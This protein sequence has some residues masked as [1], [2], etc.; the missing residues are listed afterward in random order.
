MLTQ[1]LTC[2]A[3]LAAA[4][5][6]ASP[7]SIQDPEPPSKKEVKEVVER[8]LELD[9]RSEAGWAERRELLAR[10]ELLPPLTEK[11]AASWRKD[12]AKRHGRGAE[13][14]SK[15]GRHWFF[16]DEERGKYI[17][18]GK[19]RRPKG[20]L[21]ALHGG[22]LNQGDAG[23][24][25]SA[26]GSA[27]SKL[28]WV[29][30][31][32]EV[33]DKTDRGWTTSGTEEWV[34]ELLDRAIRTFGVDPDRVY[35]AGHSMGGYGTWTLGARHADRFAGLAM[36]AG[37]PTPVFSGGKVVGI[38]KGI[39]PNLRNVRVRVYQ[40]DDDVQVLPEGNRM[41]AKLMEEARER[42][43]GYDFEY[44]EESGRGHGF[45]PGGTV[46]LLEKLADAERDAR[47]ERIVWE[48]R[49]PWVRQMHWIY[50]EKP[51]IGATVVADLDRE[52]NSVSVECTGDP[53]GLAVLLDG[54]LLDLEREVVVNLNG[55]EVYRG[56]PERTLST[57]LLTGARP[58]PALTFEC[59]IGVN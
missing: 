11:E 44:W 31:A 45:P 56:I 16:E 58:D 49:L 41:A 12:L 47:P 37:A 15:S 52:A 10:L 51:A 9:G 46:A 17:V 7:A 50:W 33:L 18:G 14:E 24:A 20:L 23:S 8:Y 48:P 4:L 5:L 1:P 22:G 59:R 38:E 43:G 57:L 19:T 26:W 21:F 3:V 28:D 53:A 25:A 35:L 54:G 29:F 42:W 30:V 40:S 6:A 27:A 34:M 2:G 36:S 32:P 55:T 39:V 13:L